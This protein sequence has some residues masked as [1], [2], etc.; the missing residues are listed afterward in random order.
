M[1]R[2]YVKW[3]DAYE[4]YGWKSPKEALKETSPKMVC[5]TFGWLVDANKKKDSCFS[6]I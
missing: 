3:V 4:T 5:K 1:K 2:V 6:Y